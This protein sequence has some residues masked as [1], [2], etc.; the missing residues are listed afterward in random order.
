MKQ[1][2]NSQDIERKVLLILKILNDSQEPVG[3]R[4]IARQMK[5][6]GMQLSER[7]VHYHLK[8]MDERG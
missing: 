5:E 7:T 8:L 3:A 2:F 4:V 6:Q 1:L